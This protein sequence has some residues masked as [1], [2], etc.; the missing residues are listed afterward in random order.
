MISPSPTDNAFD[1]NFGLETEMV[2][3]SNSNEN[4]NKRRHEVD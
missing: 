2:I 4:S 1:E 3:D